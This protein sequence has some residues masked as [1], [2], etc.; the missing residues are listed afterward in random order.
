MEQLLLGGRIDLE[1]LSAISARPAR[2]APHGA[3]FWNDP[4]IARQ[5]LAAH[6]NPDTDAASRRP[7]TIER[8]VNWLMEALA[9]RPGSTLLDLGCGPGLYCQRF[10]ERGLCVTG[11]DV[12]GGSLAYARGVSDSHALGIQYVE[13]DYLTL[14]AEAAYDAITLI[15]YDL[16]VLPD[17]ARDELLRRIR[18]ALRPGG[19]FTF[20]LKTPAS[21]RPPDGTSRW[22]VSSA[23]FWR[24]GPC[25][26]LHQTFWYSET[27]TELR[28]TTIVDPDGTATVYRI[29][30][31]LYTP[32]TITEVLQ[33]QG[34][35][36]RHLGEDL[37][38]T[39][40]RAE[41]TSLGIIA[42]AAPD[43]PN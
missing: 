5:M 17:D 10:A 34:F 18:R 26:E 20:D 37:A 6:L 42:E 30:E 39:A 1:R 8:T 25:L 3:P 11:L 41:S 7:D 9:L 13:A 2:F 36:V 43:I 19:R 27:A 28:Q 23:G 24:A 4:H 14:D 29:W 40:Y 16:G 35:R 12:S 22:Q 33:R 31:Q 32:A 21:P 38:G 15:Y